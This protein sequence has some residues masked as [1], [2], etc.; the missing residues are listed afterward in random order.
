MIEGRGALEERAMTQTIRVPSVGSIV[1]WKDHPKAPRWRVDRIHGGMATLH[2][3]GEAL[4]AM[5]LR[6]SL[7]EELLL[8]SFEVVA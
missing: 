7:S 3:A 5:D 4:R 8:A 2:Y 1:A 6:V